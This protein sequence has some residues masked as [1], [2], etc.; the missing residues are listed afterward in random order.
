MDGKID[1]T[2]EKR[3]RAEEEEQRGERGERR[4]ERMPF[5]P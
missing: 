4:E 1:S 5:P 3:G 2:I